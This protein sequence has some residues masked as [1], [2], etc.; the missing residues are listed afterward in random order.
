ML[1]LMFGCYALHTPGKACK[2]YWSVTTSCIYDHDTFVIPQP[3]H[4]D[5][6][7]RGIKHAKKEETNE[8]TRIASRCRIFLFHFFHWKVAF[9]MPASLRKCKI[10]IFWTAPSVS[11]RGGQTKDCHICKT[12]PCTASHS[13]RPTSPLVQSPNLAAVLVAFC[14]EELSEVL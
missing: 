6:M 4:T 5:T 8:K 11:W 2:T 13:H 7:R 1:S 10:Q 9:Q 12:L 3:Q 14:Y